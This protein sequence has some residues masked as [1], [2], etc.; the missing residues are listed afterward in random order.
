MTST[1]GTW[2]AGVDGAIPGIIMLANPAKG[3][4]YREEYRPTVAEDVALVTQL[5]ATAKTPSK[6]YS[7]VVVTNTRDLLDTTKDEDKYFAPGVGFVRSTGLVNGHREEI[8][9]TSILTGK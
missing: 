9:L 4:A 7:N 1:A 2:E 6:T 8:W 3:D 5:G